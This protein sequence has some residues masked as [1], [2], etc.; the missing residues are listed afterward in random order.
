MS[1]VVEYQ[2]LYYRSYMQRA[3]YGHN[4]SRIHAHAHLVH[5]PCRRHACA[6]RGSFPVSSE[7]SGPSSLVSYPFTYT[8]VA[9]TQ[10]DCIRPHTHIYKWGGGVLHKSFSTSSLSLWQC[11]QL[12]QGWNRHQQGSGGSIR[13]CH[14]VT[15]LTSSGLPLLIPP[16]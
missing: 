1:V 3:G 9:T 15:L 2:S 4:H 10:V 13:P 6:P 14:V 11:T 7:A 5:D 16:K 8:L 12:T